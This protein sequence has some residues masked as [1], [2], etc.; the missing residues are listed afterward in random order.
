MRDNNPTTNNRMILLLIGGIPLTMI[1]AATWLW[2]F[3][4]R[5]DLDL[6]AAERVASLGLAGGAIERAEVPR[7]LGVI[8]DHR[9]IEI[10]QLGGHQPNTSNT[11]RS[12]LASASTSSRVL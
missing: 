8:E 3:V 10:A 7:L 2:Y 4:A 6:V 11:V 12:P 9:L 1:L 5:G